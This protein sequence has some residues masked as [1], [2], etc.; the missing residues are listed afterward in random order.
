[1]AMITG[2]VTA[3][4]EG[5]PVEASRMRDNRQEKKNVEPEAVKDEL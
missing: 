3:T 2:S 1:M 5:H 4:D